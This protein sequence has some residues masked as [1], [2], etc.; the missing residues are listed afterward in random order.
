MG[1]NTGFFNVGTDGNTA[2][3]AVESVR[4]WWRLVGKDAY[5]DAERLLV[6]WDTGGSNGWRNQGWKAGLAELAR[7]TG[8]QITVCHFPPGTYPAHPSGA[9]SS[10]GCSPGSPWAGAADR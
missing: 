3:L 7:E 5:P 2:A 9:K 8:L 6:T 1:A 10:T 4:R